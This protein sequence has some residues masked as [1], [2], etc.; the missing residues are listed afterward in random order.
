MAAA[1]MLTNEV[2]T[3]TKA[4]TLSFVHNNRHHV[5]VWIVDYTA[6]MVENNDN[7]ELRPSKVKF[8]LTRNNQILAGWSC[9]A[10]EF[11]ILP[12]FNFSPLA[13]VCGDKFESLF[14]RIS[15]H[16][17]RRLIYDDEGDILTT[18]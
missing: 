1:A 7:D 2:T 16:Q 3:S 9:S 10:G 8:I 4:T 11:F 14:S 17:R 5:R 13:F 6:L 15:Q 18:I 12:I